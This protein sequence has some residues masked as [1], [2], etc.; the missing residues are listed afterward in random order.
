MNSIT[1]YGR[2]CSSTAY[3]WTTFSCRTLA[4]DRASRRNR[5]RAGELAANWGASTL[6]ATTR[7]S[8][9]SKARNT[10]LNPPPE[11]FENLVVAK[12]AQRL[13]FGGRLQEVQGWFVPFRASLLG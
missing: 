11:D 8:V 1:R 9:S 7:C 10:M 4:D 3:T 12:P 2:G 5:L 13:G 6:T